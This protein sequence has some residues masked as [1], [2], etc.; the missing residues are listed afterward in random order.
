[1]TKPIGYFASAIDGT[2][3][4]AIL[5]EIEHCC[6]SYLEKL[7]SAQKAA[8]ILAL[9]AEAQ[10][11]EGIEIDYLIPSDLP[12]FEQLFELSNACKL[13]LATAVLNYLRDS[14]TT[15]VQVA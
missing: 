4:N 14:Y 10:E 8:W 11:P 13:D 6:G 7:T 5:A 9:I 2:Q 15:G 3:D 1:M 12:G